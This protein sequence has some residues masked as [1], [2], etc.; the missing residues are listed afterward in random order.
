MALGLPYINVIFEEEAVASIQRSS[1]GVVA[2]VIEDATAQVGTFVVKSVKDIPTD[3]TQKNQE[4]VKLALIGGVN[5]PEKVIVVVTQAG[6]TIT[7]VASLEYTE[8]NWLA[9]PHATSEQKA[10]VLSLVE[11]LRAKGSPVKYVVADH[12]ANKYFAINLTTKSIATKNGS[13]STNEFTCRIAGLLAGTPLSISSTYQV[14]PDVESIA[15]HTKEELET[16]VGNGEFRLFHDGRKIKVARGV[17]S[18]SGA[19]SG[20][21][22]SF[23]KIKVV[24]IADVIKTD[25]SKTIEDEY[26]GKYPNS[27]DN[28]MLIVTAIRGYLKT[29]AREELLDSA[30]D[31]TCDIDL[32]AQRNYL[33]SIGVNVDELSDDDIKMYNT[34]DKLFLSIKVKILD[35]IE[36]VEIVVN[37]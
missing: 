15:K 13:Y 31:N 22:T 11:E 18:L 21:P 35:A 28:K 10:G 19:S 24:S 16:G 6:G 33:Q 1:R 27:Y 2:L 20:I 37:I 4:L 12:V 34:H 29:L 32:V 26:I 23:K 7:G 8:F 14:L 30:Y 36:E 5:M 25:V 17:T 3:L 9:T